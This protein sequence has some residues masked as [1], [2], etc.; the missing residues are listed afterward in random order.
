MIG[1]LSRIIARWLS[2]GLV[3]LGVFL[4]EDAQ[5]FVSDPDVLLLI[6]GA[7]G[8]FTEF[9]YAQAKKRGWTT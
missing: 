5:I 3:A 9:M 7:L 2:G 8:A 4:P 1:P 6:G